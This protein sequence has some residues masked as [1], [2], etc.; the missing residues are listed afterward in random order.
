MMPPVLTARLV[1]AAERGELAMAENAA[2]IRQAASCHRQR[3]A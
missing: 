1:F 2:G 3:N